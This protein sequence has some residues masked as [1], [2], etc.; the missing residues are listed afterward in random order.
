MPVRETIERTTTDEEA[1]ALTMGILDHIATKALAGFKD[2]M[3]PDQAL[4]DINNIARSTLDVLKSRRLSGFEEPLP[5]LGRN[6]F[7]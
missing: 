6:A 1:L 7:A 5:Y 4:S 2:E 3:D